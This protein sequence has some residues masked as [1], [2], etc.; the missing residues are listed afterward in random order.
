MMIDEYHDLVAYAKLYL[1]QSYSFTDTLVSDPETFLF[2]K[3]THKTHPAKIHKTP[4]PTPTNS[5]AIPKKL[6]PEPKKEPTQPQLEKKPEPKQNETPKKQKLATADTNS[7][8]FLC[9]K[10]EKPQNVVLTDI[11]KK[12]HGIKKEPIPT[13]QCDYPWK[14]S[15]PECLV[16]SFF[17][18]ESSENTFL[19]KMTQTIQERRNI[20]AKLMQVD[21]ATQSDTYAYC[22]TDILRAV[23]IAHNDQEKRTLFLESLPYLEETTS[24][25]ALTCRYMLFSVPIY[26]LQFQ[27]TPSQLQKQDLWK[28][29]LM[30]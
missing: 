25:S 19:Q 27:D 1:L 18:K 26:E 3:N 22:T 28:T 9:K 15:Y 5:S 30:M 20:R 29:L 14:S 4:S 12:M 8:L 24:T 7:P 6:L 21:A 13:L 17:P 16:L 2:F 23:F 11:E 10:P